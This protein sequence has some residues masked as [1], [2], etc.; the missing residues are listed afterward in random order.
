MLCNSW[1]KSMSV[2]PCVVAAD[3]YTFFVE[4]GE[5]RAHPLFFGSD[6]TLPLNRNQHQMGS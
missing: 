4:V 5:Q 2:L 3:F 1:N 6:G